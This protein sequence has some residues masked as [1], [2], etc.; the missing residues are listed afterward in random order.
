MID[1]L[2]RAGIAYSFYA[3]SYLLSLIKKLDI[4]II[5]L[6]KTI[7]GFSKC[8]SNAVTQFSH[9]MFDTKTSVT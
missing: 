9:D 6:H 5:S 1:T 7:C 4:K 8:K 3:V 2:I